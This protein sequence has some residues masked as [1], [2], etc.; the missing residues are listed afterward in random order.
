MTRACLCVGLFLCLAQSA[1]LAQAGEETVRLNEAPSRD[2][3]TARCAMCHS[4][5]YIQLNAAVMD[6][7]GW[8]RSV[9]K[10]IDRFGAP[11]SDEEARLIID[12]LAKQYSSGG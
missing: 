5:D 12:Y 6:R 4:L 9:R 3:T 7:A 8:E 2:I 1:S 10:M 11:I